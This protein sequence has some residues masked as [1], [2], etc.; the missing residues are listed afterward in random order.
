MFINNKYFKNLSYI[1]L[2]FIIGITDI[3]GH[4]HL[5]AAMITSNET[6]EDFIYFYKGLKELAENMV[7]TSDYFTKSEYEEQA[8]ISPDIKQASL[9]VT[10]IPFRIWT[11]QLNSSKYPTRPFYI[12]DFNREKI[13]KRL[14]NIKGD[15]LIDNASLSYA[16]DNEI[17]RLKQLM[18]FKLSIIRENFMDDKELLLVE[19]IR[20]KNQED[21]STA[22]FLLQIQSMTESDSYWLDSGEF[23]NLI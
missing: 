3:Q 11:R 9:E 2:I 10:Q 23:A 13:K 22:N 5:I 15:I 21:L 20:C 12:F 4:F 16:V 14:I 7:P 19:S 18:P 6:E 8:F 17:N 1:Y